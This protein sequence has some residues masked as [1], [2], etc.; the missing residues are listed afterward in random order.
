[1]ILTRVE[2]ILVAI[3]SARIEQ[4]KVREESLKHFD[5]YRALW[6]KANDLEIKIIQIRNQLKK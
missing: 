5:K 3:Q 1:M 4:T 2:D 6:S